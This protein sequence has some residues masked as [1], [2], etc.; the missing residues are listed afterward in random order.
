MGTRRPLRPRPLCSEVVTVHVWRDRCPW[1]PAGVLP[2]AATRAHV[3]NATRPLHAVARWTQIDAEQPTHRARRYSSC[4]SH[5][6][7]GCADL[8]TIQKFNNPDE[9]E[10]HLLPILLRAR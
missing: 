2:A 8:L 10:I 6:V 5:R 1:R 7:V 4:V 3:K 9:G